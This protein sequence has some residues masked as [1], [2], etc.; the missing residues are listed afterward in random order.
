MCLA[1]RSRMQCHISAEYGRW[2]VPRIVMGERTNAGPHFAESFDAGT[3]LAGEYVVLSAH[4]QREPVPR[5]H[6][7]AGRPDLDVDLV[8]FARGELLFLV[9]CVIG[10]I[11]QRQL[12]IELAMRA[13]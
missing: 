10:T 12:R 9:V 7:D 6:D 13:P 1:I 2:P 4:R 5:R 11:R 3:R 8:D